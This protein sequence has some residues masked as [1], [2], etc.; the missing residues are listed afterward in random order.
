MSLSFW[1]FFFAMSCN[2]AMFIFRQDPLCLNNELN[3]I[4][5]SCRG[6]Q[7]RSSGAEFQPD[8]VS[9]QAETA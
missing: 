9:Y 1:G 3:I 6:V 5:V 8:F 4:T 2:A 7:I